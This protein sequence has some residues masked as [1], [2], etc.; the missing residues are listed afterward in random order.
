[1]TIVFNRGQRIM[2][3]GY[4]KL[5]TVILLL[6]SGALDK[7]PEMGAKMKAARALSRLHDRPCLGTPSP[8]HRMV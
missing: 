6:Q 1:M 2:D 5:L 4:T 7:L 8:A 3:R